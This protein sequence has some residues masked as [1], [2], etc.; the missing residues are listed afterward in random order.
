MVFAGTQH[1]I[2]AIPSLWVLTAWCLYVLLGDPQFDRSQLWNIAPLRQHAAA[3]FELFAIAAVIG[4]FLVRYYSPKTFLSLPKS[5]PTLW[6]LIMVLYPVLSVYPQG[7]VY[8]AF[9]FHRY[10]PLLGSD[11]LTVVLSAAAFS[12]V[13]IIFRNPLA[14]GLSFLAGMLF[15]VRYLQTGSLFVSSFEHAFYGCA[16]FTIGLGRW[17]FHS[18]ARQVFPNRFRGI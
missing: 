5:N 9:F 10:W 8:R 15:A 12:W 3:I 7:I 2:P 6:A 11:W 16:I 4:A 17:F 13:H 18:A 1:R 14:V